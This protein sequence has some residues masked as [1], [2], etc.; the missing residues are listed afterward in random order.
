MYPQPTCMF[1]QSKNKI[2]FF[3]SDEKNLCI[4]HGQVFVMYMHKMANSRHRS[5][6][7]VCL[8]APVSLK[9]EENNAARKKLNQW[10]LRGT[11]VYI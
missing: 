7:P 2:S 11:F 6:P 1:C 8:L 5:V 4:L 9:T 10:K 3:F